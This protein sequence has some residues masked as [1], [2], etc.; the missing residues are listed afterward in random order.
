MAEV[1]RHLS[2]DTYAYLQKRSVCFQHIAHAAVYV[3][4]LC[5]AVHPLFMPY[6]V[7]F[8]VL[9]TVLHP[10]QF[11]LQ[12]MADPCLCH[13]ADHSFASMPWL[14]LLMFYRTF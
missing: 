13:V 6:C 2:P 8:C 5:V 1:P 14:G 10:V 7:L 12:G 4:S 11:A 9:Q 3:L